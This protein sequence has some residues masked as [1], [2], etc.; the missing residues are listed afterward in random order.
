MQYNLADRCIFTVCGYFRRRD[1]FETYPLLWSLRDWPF[2][3][4]T[5]FDKCIL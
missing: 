3:A 5:A 4:R 1:C 2:S